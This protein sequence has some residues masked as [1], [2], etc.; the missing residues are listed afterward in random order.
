M[1]RAGLAHDMRR[2][3][4]SSARDLARKS[5]SR[6]CNSL[7]M[8][9]RCSKMTSSLSASVQLHLKIIENMEQEQDISKKYYTLSSDI[10]KILP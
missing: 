9:S 1:G 3:T 2:L 6:R 8:L 10:Y 4:V 5:A 7:V